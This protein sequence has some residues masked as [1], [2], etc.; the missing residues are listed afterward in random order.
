MRL[1]RE[2]VADHLDVDLLAHVVPNVAHEVFVDPG[3]KL[4]HPARMLVV[5]SGMTLPRGVA[6]QRVVFASPPCCSGPPWPGAPMLAPILA[7]GKPPPLL[8]IC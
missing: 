4:A 7:G 2:F 6:H 5:M 8:L 3:L 1:P